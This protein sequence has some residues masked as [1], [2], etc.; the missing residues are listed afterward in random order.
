MRHNRIECRCGNMVI[1]TKTENVSQFAAVII[2]FPLCQIFHRTSTQQLQLTSFS[3]PS[4]CEVE[5]SRGN[6]QGHW[7]NSKD[8]G[9]VKC[10]LEHV[11]SMT[12]RRAC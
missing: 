1:T 11:Y 7:E 8:G 3:S 2:Q 12:G 10:P 9:G 6:P 5:E 4:F